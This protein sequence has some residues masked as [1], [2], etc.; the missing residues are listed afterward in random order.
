MSHSRRTVLKGSAALAGA[1]AFGCPAIVRAQSDKI[2]IG[3]LTPLTGFLGA[4][5]AYGAA[6]GSRFNGFGETVTMESKDAPWPSMYGAA[7]P[8]VVALPKRKRTKKPK[9]A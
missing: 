1:S 5:G 8:P 7:Q 4:L 2:R 3:H 9:E 6:M